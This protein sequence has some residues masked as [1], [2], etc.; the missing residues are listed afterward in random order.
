MTEEETIRALPDRPHRRCP[1][2]GTRVADGAKTCLMCGAEL[3]GEEAPSGDTE[4]REQSDPAP[5]VAS[6]DSGWEGEPESVFTSAKWKPL[7]IA[8]LALVTVIILAGAVILGMDLS[9]GNIAPELPTFTPTITLTPT[10]T[11]SPTASPTPTQTP[12]PTET[13]T[14]I[15][16][17]EHVVQSGDSLLAIALEFNLTIDEL[18]AY[19]QLESELI[20]EGQSLFIP[21]DTPTPGPPPTAI[22][23]Q[24]TAT[25]AAFTLHTVRSGDTLS[26]IAEEYGVSINEIRAANDIPENSESIQINQV[27]TIPRSTP[28]PEPRTTVETTL[29]PTPGLVHYPAPSMLYP[30]EDAAFTG[31]DAV[32]AL[33]WSSVGIL[34]D[35]EYYS[36]ELIA[37]SG[38]DTA[39]IRAY[40]RSTVWRVPGDLYAGDE[41]ENRAYSWRVIIVRQVTGGVD[42][43][44]KN[45]GQAGRRRGFTW[46]PGEVTA[47]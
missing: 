42:P 7:R 5:G 22:P 44:Y 18:I 31:P 4:P 12:L 1:E 39:T 30:P 20:V 45:I 8:I 41:A 35:R 11:P 14:P 6:D 32:I 10:I 47:P 28:T 40:T 46:E 17:I 25:A 36:V 3:E 33:Q 27:L 15:P 23:G 43:D 19:N 9:Q 38:D 21:P 26:T 13:P 16:P 34:E 29:T 37:P 24:P 2:C